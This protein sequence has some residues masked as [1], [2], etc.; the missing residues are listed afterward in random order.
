MYDTTTTK[1]EDDPLRNFIF[2][3]FNYF[4]ILFSHDF[5]F[6]YDFTFLFRAGTFIQLPL[7]LI[8][9]P[10]VCLTAKDLHLPTVTFCF[11]R[12]YF[13]FISVWQESE[14]FDFS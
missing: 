13:H 5:N 11:C 9:P 14:G 3:Q 12:V 7:A 10:G 6:F 1:R 4:F 8:I 2:I